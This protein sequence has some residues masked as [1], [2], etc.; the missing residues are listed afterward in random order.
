MYTS[1]RGFPYIFLTPYHGSA[2]IFP[3]LFTTVSLN[4]KVDALIC[5]MNHSATLSLEA[6]GGVGHNADQANAIINFTRLLKSALHNTFRLA[7][8][9]I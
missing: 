5:A 8:S 3:L 7:V 2:I 9:K 6:C 4:L 1:L